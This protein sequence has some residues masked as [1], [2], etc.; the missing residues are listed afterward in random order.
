MAHHV[1]WLVHYLINHIILCTSYLC[2]CRVWNCACWHIVCETCTCCDSSA[3]RWTHVHLSIAMFQTNICINF[4]YLDSATSLS[5]LYVVKQIDILNG[6]EVSC[7][8]TLVINRAKFLIFKSVFKV[9]CR[10]HIFV[11][12]TCTALWEVTCFHMT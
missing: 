2:I 1:F 7:L 5:C 11:D 10:V 6:Y 8:S 9:S 4:N 3:I 12:N